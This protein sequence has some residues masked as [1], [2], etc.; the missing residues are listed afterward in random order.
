MQ[1]VVDDAV[2]KKVYKGKVSK[3]EVQ[4]WR[5]EGERN[6]PDFVVVRW[7]LVEELLD[8][9]LLSHR[10]DIGNLVVRQGGEVEVD[11]KCQISTLRRY[12]GGN[13]D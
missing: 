9:I 2:K 7:E 8:A 12:M 6:S 11:L 1:E 3:R 4:G 5:G 10:I 13:S